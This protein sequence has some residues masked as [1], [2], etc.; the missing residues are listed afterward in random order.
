[1]SEERLRQAVRV[2]GLGIFDHDHLADTIQWSPELRNILGFEADEVVNLPEWIAHIY[3]E[4]RARIVAAIKRAHDPTGD[5]IYSVEHRA[6]R[7]DGGIRWISIQ[8][9]T[10]FEGHAEARHPVRTIGAV[11]D[12]TERR[13]ANESL[14]QRMEELAT[15]NAMSR[16]AGASLSLEEV[17]AAVMKGLFA[18]TSPTIT[19]MFLLDGDRLILKDAFP[20]SARQLLA[21]IPEHRVG[22]CMC[23]MAVREGKP[24]YSLDLLKDQR[25]NCE[26]CKKVGVKSF[27]ALPLNDGK[28]ILGVIGLASDTERDFEQQAEFLETLAAQV[29]TA[30]VN[31]RL[32]E[33]AQRELTE[34]KRAEAELRELNESLEQ[35][36][37][38]RTAEVQHKADQ[39]RALATELSRTE[40]RE[41]QRL[42]RVLH[43]DIQQMLV[44]AKLQTGILVNRHPDENSMM[45]AQRIDD[46]IDQ[47]LSASRTLTTELSP[48]ILYS[49]G[50]GPALHWLA[51]RFL[52]KHGLE[53]EIIFEPSE[54]PLDE[55]V[56]IFM[57][58]AIREL[59]FNTV[60]HSGVMKA[61]VKVLL[62][63][64]YRVQVVVSDEGKGFDPAQLRPSELYGGLGLFS[65]Q[66]RLQ[67]MGGRLDINSAPR[68]GTR[69]TL[70]APQPSGIRPERH[71]LARPI[72]PASSAEKVSIPGKINVILV[73]DH[74][75]VRQGMISLLR[76]QPDIE[77]VGEASDGAE[78]VNLARSIHPDIVLM[79]VSMPGTN[80]IDATREIHRDLPEIQIIGLSM[81]EE[82]ELSSAMREAGA[83]D[84]V[85]KGGQP[86]A[87]ISA[88]HKAL[89]G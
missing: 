60:K 33:I 1:M 68:Q 10:F 48:P 62:N 81:H 59:L 34:R 83:V 5:G 51:R 22:Q 65:I 12:I 38:E 88:I 16:T 58:E 80:G 44:A 23:G 56:R 35:R 42:A 64:E 74:H 87:L 84:Y 24:L 14:R 9:R 78:A 39:L 20:S 61:C 47:T 85:T 19:F 67:H 7:H 66:Q 8:S 57:F 54:E 15:I 63:A 26:D 27:A 89:Q 71:E 29:S 6:V 73:D 3:H 76:M 50:L 32:F 40:Q 49:G 31:A 72:Q 4:D 21:A 25:S 11:L 17:T 28:Q 36:I 37:S 77:V 69:I 13:Q 82:G 2:A 18:V 43:E 53:V 30:F 55:N 86:E 52:E 41:R 75:I 70:T 79:D 46:L 45:S